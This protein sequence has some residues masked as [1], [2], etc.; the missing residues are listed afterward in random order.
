MEKK[1]NPSAFKNLINEKT[2]EKYGSRIQSFDKNFSKQAFL[3]NLKSLHGLELKARVQL[4]AAE[5]HRQ[6]PSTDKKSFESLKELMSQFDWSGFELWPVGDYLGSFGHK[7][8]D[9]S[10]KLMT[11]LTE[12]FTSEFAIR[13]YLIQNPE[14]TYAYLMKMTQSSNVHHRRWASEGSRPR[15]PW[16]EKLPHAIQDPNPGLKILEKLKA[17]SELYVRKSVANHLNDI[18]KDHPGLVIQTL[19]AWQKDEL[20]HFDFIKRQA[21]RTL[22]KKGDPAALRL[23]GFGLQDKYEI[24]NFKISKNKIRMDQN[25]E[26]S[27]EIK[28]PSKK[29]ITI[30]VD[31]VLLLKKSNGALAPKVFKL[32]V[33][34]LKP[35]E[36][37]KVSKRHKIKLITTRKYYSGAQKIALLVNG[38]TLHEKKWELSL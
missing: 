16:G 17:D 1:D 35:N 32:K 14:K 28:N 2:V 7:H 31:Y 8:F 22:I 11:T 13:S 24:K 37:L 33:I 36:S 5:L 3:K 20:P 12:K 18:S 15:L 30:N 19:K 10:L 23:M 34:R 29:N 27:F 25:L 9:V 38:Q 4:I 26:F 21:L 6:F